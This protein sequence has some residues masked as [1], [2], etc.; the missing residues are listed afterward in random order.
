MVINH[1]ICGYPNL[2][3]WLVLFSRY[4]INRTP[5]SSVM[6]ARVY[7]YYLLIYQILDPQ[8]S[9]KGYFA[10]YYIIMI[11]FNLE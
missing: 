10:R 1:V 2:S 8:D 3:E 4:V 5:G 11:G 6:W 7:F 9:F